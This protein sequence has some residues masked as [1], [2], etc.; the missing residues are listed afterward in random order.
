MSSA[1]RK[2]NGDGARARLS[3]RIV[4]AKP[5]ELV[6]RLVTIDRTGADYA[7]GAAGRWAEELPDAR[8]SAAW[9]TW[10]DG[11]ARPA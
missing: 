11:A 9:L 7:E 2:R 3:D 6:D 1:V 10:F 4:L 8:R 5:G